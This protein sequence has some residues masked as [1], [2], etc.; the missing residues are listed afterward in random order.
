MRFFFDCAMWHR[1]FIHQPGIEA[2]P[3][4]VKARSSNHGAARRVP[5]L[6]EFKQEFK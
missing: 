5:H 1:I 3:M 4:V 6:H 2:R